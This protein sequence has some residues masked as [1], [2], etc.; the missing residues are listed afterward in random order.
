MKNQR[1]SKS[2]I[3]RR[4][5]ITTVGL[6]AGAST[7]IPIIPGILPKR[8]INTLHPN[9][10]SMLKMD[11]SLRLGILIPPSNIYPQMGENLL[12]GIS[13]Y[14]EQ[15]G[16]STG[17]REIVLLCEQTGFSPNSAVQKSRKLIESDNVDLVTG[18]VDTVINV[19]LRNIFHNN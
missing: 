2:D 5:F 13:L 9:S 4:K 3:S 16:K 7:I 8:S 1:K 14:F 17:D 10:G 11:H 6:V 15:N 19:E 12:A 18:I